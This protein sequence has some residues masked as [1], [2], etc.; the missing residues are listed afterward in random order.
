MSF[1]DSP[2][3]RSRRRHG[4]TRKVWTVIKGYRHMGENRIYALIE[5]KQ[6]SL[7]SG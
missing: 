3:D 4:G 2:M 1:H 6:K 7:D 5:R